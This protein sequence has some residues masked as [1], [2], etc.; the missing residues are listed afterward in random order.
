MIDPPPQSSPPPPPLAPTDPPLSLLFGRAQRLTHAREFEAVYAAR[1]RM[2]KGPLIVS[3]LPGERA[4]PRL[5]LAIGRRVGG[6]VV[7]VRLKRMLRE[8]FR[9]LQ[10]DLP[11]AAPMQGY[12]L[13]IGARPHQPLSLEAYIDLLRQL[14]NQGHAEHERR[15][16]KATPPPPPPPP[17]APAPR[18]A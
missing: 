5:G 10:H 16:R 3:L 17:P 15:Q 4:W 11:R 14:V 7:R 12:D 1:L 13:V 18:D 2:A 8:A 6:A 9:L